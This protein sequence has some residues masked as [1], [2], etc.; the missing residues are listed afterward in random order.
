MQTLAPKTPREWH[1]LS[2]EEDMPSWEYLSNAT[3]ESWI[4]EY[5]KRYTYSPCVNY[6]K[7]V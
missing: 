3:K 4:V 1:N 2:W 7:D 5:D 6:D